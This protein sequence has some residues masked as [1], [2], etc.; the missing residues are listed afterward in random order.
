MSKRFL[1]DED[2]VFLPESD[3]LKAG[4]LVDAVRNR[5]WSVHPE[6]GL[7]LFQSNRRR[8]GQIRGA[9]PQCNQNEEIVRRFLYEG[10]VIKRFDLVLVP[11]DINDYRN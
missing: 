9:S 4:G 6:R 7:R 10:D 5:Y 8:R 11:I 1:T 3:V 2:F